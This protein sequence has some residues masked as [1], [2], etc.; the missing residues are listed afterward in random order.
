V[1]FVVVPIRRLDRYGRRRLT[2]AERTASANYYSALGKNMGIK[3]IAA[4][5][6]EFADFLD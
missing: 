6:Q 2:E 5:H 4:T 1:P 3:K